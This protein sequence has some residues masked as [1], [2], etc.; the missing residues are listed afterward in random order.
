MS[1]LWLILVYLKNIE[2]SLDHCNDMIVIENEYSCNGCESGFYLIQS[3][4]NEN[5][6]E[7]SECEI[8]NW[9]ICNDNICSFCK[10]GSYLIENNCLSCDTNCVSCSGSPDNCVSCNA[11]KYLSDG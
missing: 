2:S 10:K 8:P 1:F 6:Y 3:P 7:C 5:I 11:G 4:T 9:K